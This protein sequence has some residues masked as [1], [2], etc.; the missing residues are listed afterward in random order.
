[1]KRAVAAVLA[2]GLLAGCGAVGL[3][4][5]TVEPFDPGEYPA[6]NFSMTEDG[7]KL[8]CPMCHQDRIAPHYAVDAA[9]HECL[10]WECA[11]CGATWP[12]QVAGPNQRTVP[13]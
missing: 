1:M 8:I 2:L 13:K 4:P 6:W 10:R 5:M 3:K 11:N 12:T 7:K 9:K